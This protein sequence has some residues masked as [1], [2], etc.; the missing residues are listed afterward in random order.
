MTETIRV[1]AVPGAMLPDLQRQKAFVG[2]REVGVGEPADH[3]VPHGKRYAIVPEGVDVAS[4]PY[5]RRAINTGGLERIAVGVT[6]IDGA[7]VV[8]PADGSLIAGEP[9]PSVPGEPPLDPG[10]TGFASAESSVPLPD[11]AALEGPT[12]DASEVAGSRKTARNAL[13]TKEG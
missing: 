8:V 5:V 12:L 2:Y 13:R 7:P 11:G 4:T 9:V 3:A 6:T 10:V 1:R